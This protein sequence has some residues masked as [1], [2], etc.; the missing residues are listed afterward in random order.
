M[1]LTL[2]LLTA[3][4]S[5]AAEPSGAVV[6]GVVRDAQGVVQMGAHGP[7][8]GRELSDGGNGFYR[9]LWTLPD[10]TSASGKYQVRA[11]AALFVPALRGDL[12]L[13]S[14]ARAVVNLTLNT[15]FETSAWLP[16][17]RRKADEPSDDWK[18]TLRVGGEPSYSAVG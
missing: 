17:E 11:S 13:K 7:G 18:W 1:F 14:G 2:I 6:S 15:L 12:E 4:I 9:S 3:G 8:A 16:A 5:K 10:R